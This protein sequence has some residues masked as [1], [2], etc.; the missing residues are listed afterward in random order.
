MLLKIPNLLQ[1][2]EDRDFRFLSI[3]WRSIDC[4]LVCK[5]YFNYNWV[6]K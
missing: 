3:G 4:I 6:I 2:R 1:E 5:V